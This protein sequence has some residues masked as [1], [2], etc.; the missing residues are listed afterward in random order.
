MATNSVAVSLSFD[1][2]SLDTLVLIEN[3]D[4]QVLKL[5]KGFIDERESQKFFSGREQAYAIA[6]VANEA[7]FSRLAFE[8]LL[9]QLTVAN[10]AYTL[11]KQ[12]HFDLVDTSNNIHFGE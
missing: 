7:E 5:F 9:D 12:E 8:K 2:F 6:G 10:I 3:F 11:V 4:E 1:S